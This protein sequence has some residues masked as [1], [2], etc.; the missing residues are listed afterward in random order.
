MDILKDSEESWQRPRI[1]WF[2]V[3]FVVLG[4]L[5][6]FGSIY[7]DDVLPSPNHLGNFL[8]LVS[9]VFLAL[10]GVTIMRRLAYERVSHAIMFFAACVFVFSKVLSWVGEFPMLQGVPVVGRGGFGYEIL[11]THTHAIAL[12]MILIG[13]IYAALAANRARYDLGLQNRALRHEVAQRSEVERELRASEARYR[14]LVDKTPDVVWRVNREGVFTCVSPSVETVFGLTPDAVVGKNLTEVLPAGIAERARAGAAQAME[15]N[16]G[17]RTQ[18]FQFQYQR[19]DGEERIFEALSAPVYNSDGEMNE[20]QGIT[21]DITAHVRSREA[22]AVSE[23]KYRAFVENS[24]VVIARVNRELKYVFVNQAYLDTVR[25]T[26]EAVIGNDPEI[27]KNIVHPEDLSLIVGHCRDVLAGGERRIAEIRVLDETGHW[28]WFSHLVYPWYEANGQLG[29]VEA[30]ARDV[31]EQKLA[32][33]ALRES[34]VTTRALLNATS[35]LV[36]L[37]DRDG[38]LLVLN[39]HLASRYGKTPPEL[40]GV[41]VRDLVPGEVGEKRWENTQAVF[42]TGRPLR[43]SDELNGHHFEHS[44]FP[45]GDENGEVTRLAFFSRD[46]TDA[47]RGAEERIRLATAIE[48]APDSVIITGVDS[49]VQY[50]NPGFERNTGYARDDV[51]GQSTRFLRSTEHD[52]VFYRTIEETISRGAVWS[53]RLVSRRK[54]GS[55]FESDTTISPVHNEAGLIIN[56]VWL[57]HDVSLEVSLERQL[58]QAQKM[59]AVGTLAGG[60]AH[61]FNNILSLI[62]G[63]SELLLEVLPDDEVAR[64]SVRQ[65]TK[66]GNRGAELVKH[67]LTF[68]RQVERRCEPC[69]VGTILKE[70][71]RFLAASLPATV[72]IQQRIEEDMGA[73]MADPIQIYQVIMNLCTNAY[74]AMGTEGGILGLTLDEVELGPGFQADVGNPQPGTYVRVTVSDTGVGMDAAI[75]GRIFEPFYST[76]KPSQGTGLGLST[77]HGIVTSYGGAVRVRSTVG[78]GTVFEVFLPRLAAE[79][80]G[81]VF[82]EEYPGSGSERILFVDDDPDLTQ[83]ASMMLHQL[84]YKVE[85]F[86]NSLAAFEAFSADPDGFDLAI[87]D[88]IMP[89]LMGVELAKRMLQTRP[90]FPVFLLTG[91]S[92]GIT[93]EQARDLGIR[94][95]V[96]KPFSS[97]ELGG[98]IRKTLDAVTARRN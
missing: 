3:L 25:L 74:Q 90:G 92:E 8:S 38:R 50:V 55:L 52:E 71:L 13:F 73:V 85:T 27:I 35:D 5:F 66:A 15:A 77:V 16:S 86:T 31:T 70:A 21:R 75:V 84:G 19:P 88:Q 61:D 87:V 33:E 6:E 11:Q 67:I 78:Q 80:H 56:Y 28:R 49:T 51:I 53:G 22:L 46:I 94:E 7:A 9:A 82:L 36:G 24:P 54:N 23:E 2:V 10:G 39:E 58:R 89:H 26:R 32:E 63:H 20:I 34:E 79:A 29:G 72:E 69:N 83:M 42:R 14:D 60:I 81:E 65:I 17:A 1:G 68:S 41:N 47:Q 97:R 45:V 96:M 62:L 12:L 18:R 4:M 93:P 59:E 48:Q 76:K 44:F 40:A 91:Y 64:L 30:S 57:M 37:I 43:F 95:F 98:L